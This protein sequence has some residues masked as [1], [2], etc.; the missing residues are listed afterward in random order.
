MVLTSNLW[1]NLCGPGGLIFQYSPVNPK[2]SRS[3]LDLSHCFRSAN[4]KKIPVGNA[5]I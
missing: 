1:S 4:Y 3:A 5:E 2:K